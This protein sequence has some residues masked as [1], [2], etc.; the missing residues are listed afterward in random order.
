MAI[1]RMPIGLFVEELR[2]CVER[3]DGY[4]MGAKGQD[5]KGWKES[6]WWFTQYS[7]EQKKK[8]LY[9]REKAQFVWDCNGLSEGIYEKWSGVNIN[10]KARYAYDEWCGEKGK[11][12]IPADKRV[13][14]AAVY[15]GEKASDIH[16]VAY[17]DKPVVDGKPEGDWY[18]IEAR[19]VM[20]GCVR[21]L[22]NDRKP[23][24]WGWMDKYFDYDAAPA[25]EEPTPD[26]PMVEIISKG[27]SV[28]IREGNGTQ[29]AKIS[30]E[31]PGTR[32]SFVATALN[33][34]NAIEID[35]RIGWVSGEYSKVIGM[36]PEKV[37]AIPDISR[38][39]G[40]VDFDKLAPEVE[41]VIA[42][43]MYNTGKDVYFDKYAADMKRLGIP[44]G[45]YQYVTE[46]TADGAKEE[47]R[48]FYAAM[49]EHNPLFYVIDAESQDISHD[50]IR[51]WAE[52]MRA[53]GVKKLGCYVAHN[54]Y[55]NY[56]FDALRGLFDFVWIPRYGSNDG[57]VEGSKRPA[58]ACD[59][60]Q[61]TSK[62]TLPGI[63]GDVDLNMLVGDKPVGYFIAGEAR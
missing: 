49:S 51:A 17:L 26:V 62:G 8:A 13:P 33:G 29:Y 15:W 42:R 37:K 3:K 63:K 50:T 45:V 32:F 21:T 22:L 46:E 40:D 39:Q 47:A 38:W 11:G 34:W 7:G 2:A 27:G 57:T 59:L 30:A 44:F 53:L 52:E 19:G 16:H 4:I 10:T 5:P 55:D 14:G 56:N 28:N 43:G 58:Y 25:R 48:A 9:W 35:K 6:S 1:E 54:R 61:Y 18:L 12:M 23:N 60:W 36:E 20:H 31:K 41:F 24:F